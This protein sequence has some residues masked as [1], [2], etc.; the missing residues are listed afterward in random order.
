MSCVFYRQG[1]TTTNHVEIIKMDFK[2]SN[3][4]FCRERRVT[5]YSQL[6]SLIL[7]TYAYLWEIFQSNFTYHIPIRLLYTAFHL[8]KDKHCILTYLLSEETKY[9]TPNQFW[10]VRSIKQSDC[11][12]NIT[13]CMNIDYW[14]LTNDYFVLTSIGTRKH[15]VISCVR[16]HSDYA[17]NGESDHSTGKQAYSWKTRFCW[18]SKYY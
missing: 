8:R 13:I 18:C 2:I 7:F 10:F 16:S 14:L 17:N 6:L 3:T 12:R 1:D 5:C 4:A 9:T 15:Y 11:Y